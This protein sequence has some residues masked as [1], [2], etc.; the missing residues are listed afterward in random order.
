MKLVVSRTPVTISLENKT[1]DK[2][3]APRPEERELITRL[4]TPR[5]RAKWNLRRAQVRH[6][7]GYDCTVKETNRGIIEGNEV[8]VRAETSQ[9]EQ[10]SKLDS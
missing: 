5:E 1:R 4:R 6:K 7:R 2:E 9:G 3:A 10:R 8:Y